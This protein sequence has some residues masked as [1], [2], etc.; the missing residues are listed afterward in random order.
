M[1]ENTT[2]RHGARVLETTGLSWDEAETIVSDRTVGWWE[3]DVI[4]QCS[5]QMNRTWEELSLVRAQLHCDV[6]VH[7]VL[8]LGI[9]LPIL[10]V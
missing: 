3:W 4:A 5:M 8:N 10:T 9:M 2:Q 7:K 6:I 1:E